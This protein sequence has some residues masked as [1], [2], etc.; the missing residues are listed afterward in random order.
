MKLH[1]TWYFCI[2]LSDILTTINNKKIFVL[3]NNWRATHRI[4]SNIEIQFSPSL[5]ARL[6]RSKKM[7]LLTRVIRPAV[8]AR[9]KGFGLFSQC[10]PLLPSVGC[11]RIQQRW[12]AEAVRVYRRKRSGL[13]DRT[14][15]GSN[16]LSKFHC[17]PH[18]RR[19]ENL[20]VS[21]AISH[22]CL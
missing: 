5:R 7:P 20:S 11:C 22:T 3:L 1:V 8:G 18:R 15:S 16:K 19:E 21:L 12:S 14:G 10:S 9:T 17:S 4:G 13:Q 2:F 6:C